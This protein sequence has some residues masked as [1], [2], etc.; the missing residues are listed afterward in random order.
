MYVKN[1]TSGDRWL[2]GKIVKI[3]GTNMYS[4]LLNDGSNVR[5][6]ADQMRTR[7][8]SPAEQNTYNPLEMRIPQTPEESTVTDERSSETHSN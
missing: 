6:H 1:F 3:L 8:A 4:V 5:K 7:V 2:K